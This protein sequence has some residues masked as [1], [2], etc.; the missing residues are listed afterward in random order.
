MPEWWLGTI[1]FGYKD[2][3]GGFYPADL[4]PRDYLSYY[5]R[6][7]NSVE[8]D[9]TFYGIPSRQR[10]QQWKKSV[11]KNFLFCA[12]TPRKITHEM[13]LSGAHGMM[14]EFV[15]TVSELADQLGVI[16]IQFPPS[17][18]IESL[19]LLSG[20]LTRLPQGIR[21][22]VELRHSSW[23]V[24]RTA[25]LLQGCGIAWVSLDY[26]KLP[27][28]I[29][30]TSRFLYVRW[31]GQHGKYDQHTHERIDQTKQLTWWKEQIEPALG[32]IDHIFGFFNNDYAGFAAGTC[33]KF[34]KIIGLPT[35][36]TQEGRQ[37]RLF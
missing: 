19:D 26:P 25:V 1:G 14:D 35:L 8:L 6:I 37:I 16:L 27:M 30:P 24:E 10:I 36:E 22:A 15:H 4:S 31:I 13:R 23:Y 18:T 17:F 33:Q 2:W 29:L 7:F 34:K 21:Y 5:S 28:E 3:K 11:S 20:F 12:K 32:Q 9:T